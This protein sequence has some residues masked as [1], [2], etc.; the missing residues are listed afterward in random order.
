MQIPLAQNGQPRLRIPSANC[1]KFLFHFVILLVYLSNLSNFVSKFDIKIM[2]NMDD[3]EL[4]VKSDCVLI[5]KIYKR[6][7]EKKFLLL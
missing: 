7:D 4:S 2:Q 6:N 5:N 1:E 3:I